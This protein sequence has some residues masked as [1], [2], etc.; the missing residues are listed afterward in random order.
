M[1]ALLV[2]LLGLAAVGFI[3]AALFVVLTWRG[4]RRRANPCHIEEVRVNEEWL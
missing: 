3:T 4:G 1:S 2:A